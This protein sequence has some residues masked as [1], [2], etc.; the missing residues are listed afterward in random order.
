MRRPLDLFSVLTLTLL[1]LIWGF[2]QVALKLAANDIAP[3]MQIG[4]RCVFAACVLLPVLLYREG[5]SVF[6][7]GTL[8][9]GLVAGA[10]FASEFLLLGEGL[11]RTSAAH[12]V[13]FL[14]TAPLF[15][16]LGMHFIHETEQLRP[17][18]WLGLLTAFF[19]IAAIF[20]VPDSTQGYSLEGDLLGLAAGA[21]WGFTTVVVRGSRLT[22]AS[23]TKT[24]FYQLAV[25]GVTMPLVA[26]LMGKSAVVLN[27]ST[28][29]NLI[30]QCVI[31]AL[32]SYLTWFWLLRRYLASRLATFSFMTP[33]FGVS[34]GVIILDE[35][36]TPAFLVGAVA[37][38]L[39][40]L[41]VSWRDKPQ[42][43][44]L[45]E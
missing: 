26:A 25:A 36:I 32:F 37:V 10:M 6:T 20:V 22:D 1:C 34:F 42:P 11:E 43:I 23:A 28:V 7:D 5:T 14:Y 15:T 31:V 16:A 35:Q 2:Q 13:V 40:I 19:G 24:I 17:R 9:P 39:G 18:Q 12:L 44:R 41:L 29:P 3:I 45:A 8:L 30:F 21:V 38:I 33:L 4:I 27:A